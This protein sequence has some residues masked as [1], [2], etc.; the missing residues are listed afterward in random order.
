MPKTRTTLTIDEDI[1]R[2]ARIAAANRGIKEGQLI[3]EALTRY[4]GYNVFELAWTDS[5][6]RDNALDEGLDIRSM[7]DDELLQWAVDLQHEARRDRRAGTGGP[8]RTGGR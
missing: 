4:L 3:E 5:A 2:S 6:E 7:T 8:S 1:L